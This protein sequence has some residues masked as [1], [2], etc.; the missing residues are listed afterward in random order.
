MAEYTLKGKRVSIDGGGKIFVNGTFTNIKQWS[1]DS[2]RYSSGSGS[3]LK[4]IS[5]KSLEDALKLKGFL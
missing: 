3:E 5:G 4:E 1:S 2:K